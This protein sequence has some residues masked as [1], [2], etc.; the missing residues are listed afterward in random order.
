[1][2]YTPPPPPPGQDGPGDQSGGGSYGQQPPGGPYGPPPGGVPP[3]QYG[4]GYGG[5]PVPAGNNTKAIV[6]LVIGILVLP[7]GFC[8]G[9]LGLIG[10]VSILLGRS[11]RQEIA[12]SGGQQ[13][14][15]GMAKAGFILGI[16]DVVLGVLVSIWWVVAFATG[17]GEFNFNTYN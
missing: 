5:Q 2:S 12:A 6:A 1:M 17:N 3:G 15:D 13:T 16:I 10:I 9:P 7:F 14:G 11:A 8:C 4:G